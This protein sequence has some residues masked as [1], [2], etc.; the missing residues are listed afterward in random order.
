MMNLTRG[1]EFTV[2][3]SLDA[4]V[5]AFERL[6]VCIVQN[7]ERVC[8][9]K[10]EDA[11]P[12]TDGGRAYFTFTGAETMRLRP[13]IPAFARASGTLPNSTEM[14]SE[15]EEICVQDTFGKGREK[16]WS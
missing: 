1:E 13:G 4:D 11:E 15:V 12:D 8:G 5:D 3:L 2:E 14:H 7:G 16:P 9:R 6:E 10:T